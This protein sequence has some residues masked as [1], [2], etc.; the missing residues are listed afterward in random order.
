MELNDEIEAWASLQ[1]VATTTVLW[2]HNAMIDSDLSGQ[3]S[4]NEYL[5]C[6]RNP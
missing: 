1:S 6:W 2:I 4:A 3:V 5:N